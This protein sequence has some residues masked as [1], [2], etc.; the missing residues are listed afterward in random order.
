MFKKDIDTTSRK[1]MVDFLSNHYRYN[2]MNSWNQSTSYANNVKIYNLDVD[3]DIKDQMYQLLD[4]E[5]YDLEFDI[6]SLISDFE[7]NTGYS[8]G[9]N[10][11]SGGYIVL[12]E[13]DKEKRSAYPGRN[14]DMYADF[15]DE[16]E[17][18]M[19]DLKSRVELVTAFDALCDDIIAVVVDFLHNNHMIETT[20][21]IEKKINVFVPN[22]EN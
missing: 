12:Y 2:T 6:R 21:T 3:S 16:D 7:M 17:W 13:Y 22:E 5:A 14:I 9:F 8:A 20:V 11:R 10:G 1:V 15:D 18:T 4:S 19:E